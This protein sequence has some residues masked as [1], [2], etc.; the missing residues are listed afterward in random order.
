M[1]PCKECLRRASHA[2]AQTG[3]R[4]RAPIKPPLEVTLPHLDHRGTSVKARELVLGLPKHFNQ[5]RHLP[6]VERVSGAHRGV[7]A[8]GDL[9]PLLERPRG[10]RPALPLPTT[11]ARPEEL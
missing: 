4:L 2:V 7:A 5:I 11:Q 3:L 10:V 9:D 6:E 8:R 1:C